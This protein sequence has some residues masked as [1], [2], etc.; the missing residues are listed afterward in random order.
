MSTLKMALCVAV[1]LTAAGGSVAVAQA[2]SRSTPVTRAL[3]AGAGASMIGHVS[4]PV[5]AGNQNLVSTI[6]GSARLKPAQT[7]KVPSGQ[8][9]LSSR[10]QN[11][12]SE[13]AV[14]PISSPC[15]RASE[16]APMCA[17]AMP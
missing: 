15:A 12:A 6:G 1:L 13:P 2:T 3:G 7:L 5:R 10:G 14:V 11:M 16:P 17:V 4:I 8:T 9:G